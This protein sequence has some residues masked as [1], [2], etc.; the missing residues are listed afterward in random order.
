M[1]EQYKKI[2]QTEYN[3]KTFYQ[4][5]KDDVF[6]VSRAYEGTEYKNSKCKL[7]VVGRAMNGWEKDFSKYSL[8]EIVDVLFEDKFDFSDVINPK[9]CEKYH[10]CNYN[11][12]RSK[13]WKLIKF[14]LEEYGEANSN[15]YDSTINDKWNEKIVWS[16]LYKISPQKFGNPSWKIMGLNI[17]EYITILK[18]E[19]E[20]YNPERI[21]F[22]TDN[23]YLEPYKDKPT[24]INAFNIKKCNA[25]DVVGIGEHGDKKII[26]CKRPDRWGMS[27]EKIHKMAKE[28]KDAF[29]FS[30]KE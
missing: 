17:N 6:T 21:L 9:L 27:D 26:V 15:W 22:V 11:Y 30:F 25:G 28:I 12:I 10:D 4:Y 20:E 23:N 24:F 19:I 14:V 8:S 7:M 3:G 5:L 13:F 1:K 16:N 2:L 29:K 18:K